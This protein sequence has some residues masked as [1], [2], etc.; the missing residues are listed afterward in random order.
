MG[1]PC[2]KKRIIAFFPSICAPFFP[3]DAVG[4]TL[5][6]CVKG[7]S[8]HIGSS[9]KETSKLQSEKVGW[10]SNWFLAFYVMEMSDAGKLLH[11]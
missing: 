10:T 1:L 3:S 8:C 5:S 9:T 6:L 11:Q 2:R 4:L 7:I